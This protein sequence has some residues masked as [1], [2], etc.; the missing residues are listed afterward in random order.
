MLLNVKKYLPLSAEHIDT[1]G[2]DLVSV[3]RQLDILLFLHH[4][5]RVWVDISSSVSKQSLEQLFHEL[6][7]PEFVWHS[8]AL[9]QGTCSSPTSPVSSHAWIFCPFVIFVWQ[10][11]YFWSLVPE[12]PEQKQSL[13]L[14]IFFSTAR[15][16]NYQS[17]GSKA[18]LIVTYQGHHSNLENCSILFQLHRSH[19]DV[20]RSSLGRDMIHFDYHK[21]S[22]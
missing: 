1:A 9:L 15:V 21:Q 14:M 19:I 8:P 16:R 17:N 20:Q 7:V 22:C 13:V 12:P 4:F 2:Q 3:T 6:Q 5:P 11:R 18:Y 10:V